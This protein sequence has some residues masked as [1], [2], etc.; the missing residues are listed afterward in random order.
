M[1]KISLRAYNKEVEGLVDSGRIDEAIAHCRYI[2]NLFPKHIDTYRLLGKA[3]LE[4]QRYG[5]AADIL[6][7]VLSSAPDDFISHV[8]MSI[9]REDEGNLDEAI[10]HMERAFEIQPSNNAIQ[11]EL[12]RLYGRR[13]G[14]EPPKVRLTR[15]A[16][17]RMYARGDLYQQAIAEL[18]A[19]LAEDPQRLD[20]QSLLARVY[21]QAGQR[22]EAAETAN[23]VLQKLPFCIEA[24]RVLADVLAN[25]DRAEEAKGYQQR[26][27]SLDPYSAHISA[28]AP[29]SDRVPD[30]AVVLEKLAWRPGD[31]EGFAGEPGGQPEW[32]ASLGVKVESL[33]EPKEDLPDWLSTEAQQTQSTPEAASDI[34]DWMKSAGW[35]PSSGTAEEEQPEAAFDSDVVEEAGAELASADIPDWLRSMAPQES[36]PAGTPAADISGFED[37]FPPEP[38]PTKEDAEDAPI[39]A[40]SL[41][42]EKVKIELPDR[43]GSTE[44]AEPGEI[45][46]GDVPSSEAPIG[47]APD[48]LRDLSAASGDDGQTPAQ[49]GAGFPDWLMSEEAQPAAEPAPEVPDWLKEMQTGPLSQVEA[50]QAGSE[51]TSA[52]AGEV[53]EEV[54]NWVREFSSGAPAAAEEP[55]ELAGPASAMEDMGE[56]AEALSQPEAAMQEMAEA[57]E[58]ADVEA[59]EAEAPSAQAGE[60]Q[61]AA[62]FEMSEDA[63][64]AWLESLAVKQGASEALLL[65][66]E[67]RNETPP[68]WVQ[69]AA[70]EQPPAVEAE[71][72]EETPA[73]EVVAVE[74]TSVSK[75]EPPVAEVEPEAEPASE[76]PDWLRSVEEGAPATL[77]SAD[78]E[79][80]AEMP[81]GDE[82]PNWLR[83]LEEDAPVAEEPV[84]T[85]MQAVGEAEA[86][87]GELPDWLL[88]SAS[89]APAEEATEAKPDTQPAM[90][91]EAESQLPSTE[92]EDAAFAWLESLAV[93]Q[94]ADE[95]LL[96]KP[97][98]RMETPPEWVKEATTEQSPADEPEFTIMQDAASTGEAPPE[99][100]GAAEIAA[101]ERA[102][103]APGEESIPAFTAEGAMADEM[104]EAAVPAEGIP[105]WLQEGGLP[106]VEGEAVAAMDEEPAAPAELPDWLRAADLPSMAAESA[107][108]YEGE[109]VEAGELPDWLQAAGELPPVESEVEE[110]AAADQVEE[111]EA[112]L[113]AEAELPDWLQ[114]TEGAAPEEAETPSWLA[115][116]HPLEAEASAFDASQAPTLPS[117][118]RD[119]EEEAPILGDTKPVRVRA[120]VESIPEEVPASEAPMVET[121]TFEAPFAEV[122]VPEETFAE[123]P[124]LE[125]LYAE[126][127]TPETPLAEGPA[128]EATIA[129]ISEPEAG[130]MT[131]IP[132]EAEQ[133]AEPAEAAEDTAGEGM[134][135]APQAAIE[136]AGN[137]PPAVAAS[138]EV[139]PPEW[140]EELKSEAQE[141]PAA[142][143]EME[144]PTEEA[145]A[146]EALAGA[147]WYEKIEAE[148]VAEPAEP[149][150]LP[151]EASVEPEAGEA[152]ETPAAEAV[153]GAAAFDMADTDAA[154]AWLE[155]LAVKQGA[156]EALLLTPEERMETPPAWVEEAARSETEPSGVHESEVSMMEEASTEEAPAM[157][158]AVEEAGTAESELPEWLKEVSG[159]PAE[160]VQEP[161]TPPFAESAA[162]APAAPE[163]QEE[164]AAVPPFDAGPEPAEEI[165]ALPSWLEEPVAEQAEEEVEWAPPVESRHIP[166][167]QPLTVD[168]NTAS[169]GELERLP[170]VG[171]IL[172]Q[173]ILAHR[174]NYGPFARSED[175]LQVPGF[176]PANLQEIQDQVYV[177][178]PE[179]PAPPPMMEGETRP[180]LVAARTAMIEG[181]LNRAIDEYTV[182]IK[183]RRFLPEV[184][185]DL[186]DATFRYPGD[187]TVWQTLGDAYLRDDQ[188][189]QALDA[190][191][192][193]EDLLR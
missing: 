168:L 27:Q 177:E 114:A 169:L 22:A 45:P 8:G 44:A 142:A 75:E 63:A 83:S 166:E 49:P 162:E 6:Q 107:A 12:R 128:P 181:D 102:L 180:E 106:Q 38:A 67:E 183:S 72:P 124:A 159:E 71:L 151:V 148:G 50:E 87:P 188:L 13:D 69:E 55:A 111:G 78:A 116:E 42:E 73:T 110:P 9:I 51:E 1:E 125:A 178:A 189:Q 115:E 85:Y 24:N 137:E 130:A 184:V 143:V 47:D 179:A 113:M 40:A 105:S 82:L 156:E 35:T 36:E 146:V 174:E 158:E 52:A 34:P 53:A 81:A 152:A 30:Q 138:A 149:E 155:S 145:P 141:A 176:S 56:A 164:T 104:A 46:V 64:F 59:V 134:L 190:Y 2:L 163:A 112:E 187:A 140:L 28:S 84:E 21:A 29:T 20:L 33:E 118:E 167:A 16:L 90:E 57:P 150:S 18:R 95:A 160:A 173:R 68:E 109:P 191:T 153:T 165:P 96:L 31:Q 37:L 14:L 93:K 5:D 94:G 97:E 77:A 60:E 86:A 172:A 120:R 131:H 136:A 127:S 66:P 15:G 4:S 103:E 10:W 133:E 119:L 23:A 17:A 39:E 58:L 11:G 99:M 161:A 185:R 25:S 91:I 70:L 186:S 74:E 98:D 41:E 76:I 62:S 157:A 171:F 92:D 154:F 48:W 126:V 139:A 117:W 192:K 26:V 108:E 61:G 182:L 193:A 7:R 3:Y 100:G 54:P 65:T 122:P 43:L 175:L 135:F 144:M 32:A 88:E 80:A 147:A 123:G 121:P 170:G 101:P 19:A 89:S 79:P 132:V 129:E